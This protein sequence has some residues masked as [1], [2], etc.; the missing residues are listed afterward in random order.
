VA[1]HTTFICVVVFRQL[2]TRLHV[3]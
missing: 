2:K 3:R 1:L